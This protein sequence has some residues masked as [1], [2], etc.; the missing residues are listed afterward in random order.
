MANTKQLT[1][2]VRF[3]TTQAE[4][5]IDSLVKKLN[6]LNNIAN[7]TSASA[8]EQQL[9]RSTNATNR[10]NNNLRKANN[11]TNSIKSKLTA[12]PGKVRNWATAQQNVELSTHRT[13]GFLATT[14][15]RLGT[16]AT[17]Y[18]GIMGTKTLINMSDTLV[19]AEN[20]LNYVSSKQLGSQGFTTDS[21]G[22][23]TYST[24]TL[25][26]TNE[27][28]DKMYLSSQ[29][30]RTSYGDM[31]SNVSRNMTLA[32][33][34]F[35][36]NIDY[37][38]R[39]QEIM[40]E[41][42]AVGGATAQEM[43]SSMYQL[44]QALGSGI[45]AGDELRSVREGA[46]LA[47]QAI[48]K[49][50]QKVLNT[51]ESLKDLASQGKIT[52][53]MVVA[54]VMNAGDDLDTAFEQTK[55][56]F[57]QTFEQMKNTAMKAFEPVMTMFSDMLNRAVENGM[58][59]KFETLCIG[60]AKAIIIAF[61]AI[62]NTISWIADNWSWLKHLIIAGLLAIAS[63]YILTTSIAVAQAII[64]IG[65]WLA[66]YGAICFVIW[67]VLMLI[68]IFYL[69][70]TAVIDT[71]KAIALAILVIGLI[72]VAILWIIGVIETAGILALATL[73]VVLIALA[74]WFFAEVCGGVWVVVQF[75]VNAF[76]WCCNLIIA[77][78][79]SAAIILG[80]IISFI[81]NAFYA[82]C[83][84]IEVAFNN[85]V[86]F[87][88]NLISALWEVVKAICEN[89]GIAFSNAWNGAVSSFWNF[90]ANCLEGLD[91]LAKPLQAIAE[92]FGKSFD[93]GSFT[94]SVRSKGDGYNQKSY[95]SIG[96]AW[97][98]GMST[99][100]YGSPSAAASEG[101]NTHKYLS[102]GDAWN[103]G[104]NTFDAFES[105]WLSDAYNTGYNWGAGIE[106]KVNEWGSKFQTWDDKTNMLDDIGKA[107]GVDLSSMFG[108]GENGVFP[109]PNDLGLKLDEYNPNLDE[110][111]K[112]VGD[113]KDNTGS[114]ADSLELADDDL[115]FLRRVA[116]MEWRNEFTTAEIKVDMTNHNNVNSER[117]LDGIVT[118]LS[119]VLREE[120]TNV[121]YG[122]HY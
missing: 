28:L 112:S 77:I 54:A 85:C 11:T 3:N 106:D 96:D 120:M 86:A 91:W 50:A 69:W 102:V 109:D 92:L 24:K 107:L 61:K 73:I 116:E 118:Y 29:R 30:V 56:T 59:D 75:I 114:I 37:A 15:K 41:A 81:G 79:N 57:A 101:W 74:L 13:N 25:D 49:F 10:L 111:L 58:L 18:G 66:E 95:V 98:K 63:Y 27:A 64:R 68:Y 6:R 60:A 1:A 14:L 34:A 4:R 105:G 83:N 21:S 9:N 8:F 38:I 104:W 108:S 35:D 31:M 76:W 32:G 119:D 82:A 53:D 62:E 67:G 93:Y 80:N 22:N 19:G 78:F 40:A 23:K 7:S 99:K 12:I 71:C 42:Y 72:I 122:V 16:I 110:L 88:I 55:R 2:T 70:K 103:E 33:D 20:R 121:A 26:M 65:S 90:I 48:E 113:I 115:E 117:D 51:E 43:S 39:F 47:Y 94:A 100:D 87:V 84:W 36:N 89:I 46:P 5:R 52:S 45:L 97:D 17:I 44:T